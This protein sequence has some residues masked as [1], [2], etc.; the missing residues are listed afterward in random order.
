MKGISISDCE[1]FISYF[2]L[3]APKKNVAT[4]MNRNSVKNTLNTFFPC[5]NIFESFTFFE[6]NLAYIWDDTKLEAISHYRI[7]I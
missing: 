4:T 5:T 1:I 6:V 7:F 2:L 3:R